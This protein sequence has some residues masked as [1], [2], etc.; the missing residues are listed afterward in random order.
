MAIAKND[1]G[2]VL[3]Q[4]V[5]RTA[6]LPVIELHEARHTAWRRDSL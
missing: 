4:T 5:A 1:H 3:D 6:G 2:A